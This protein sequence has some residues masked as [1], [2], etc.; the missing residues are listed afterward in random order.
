MRDYNN[1]LERLGD[2]TEFILGNTHSKR[3]LLEDAC[4]SYLSPLMTHEFPP[5]LQKDWGSLW[6]AM[7]AIQAPS[8]PIPASVSAM[9]A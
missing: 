3:V 8:G 1:L 6:A 5:E 9:S 2:A 7:E 4:S